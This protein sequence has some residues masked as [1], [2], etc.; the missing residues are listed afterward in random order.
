M[1][2]L[3]LFC[4]DWC[5]G[6]PDWQATASFSGGLVTAIAAWVTLRV[7][8]SS[9]KIAR[10]ALKISVLEYEPMLYVEK[11]S[12]NGDGYI[13][14]QF[15]NR[16]ASPAMGMSLEKKEIKLEGEKS[17]YLSSTTAII[18]GCSNN[19][20]G[21]G[22][23]TLLKK[24][25]EEIFTEIN[26][27]DESKFCQMNFIYKTVLG[28]ERSIPIKVTDLRHGLFE[29]EGPDGIKRDSK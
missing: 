19:K 14:V 26:T 10:E 22:T 18:P 13:T 12:K 29:F 11:I 16:S 21:E 25:H 8:I 3:H 28:I 4:V 6:S 9:E 20:P 24:K 23:L 7:A 1:C 27:S 17:D 5:P 15:I 2:S